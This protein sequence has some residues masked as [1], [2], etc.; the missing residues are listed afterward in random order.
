MSD[1]VP[2]YRDVYRDTRMPWATMPLSDLIDRLS[3]ISRYHRESAVETCL[4][5]GNP[6]PCLTW[7]MAAGVAWRAGA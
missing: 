5:C 4:A 7:T 6:W 3:A 1:A 2:G